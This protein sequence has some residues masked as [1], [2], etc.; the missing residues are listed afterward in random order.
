M[1]KNN[2]TFEISLSVLN[3][4]GRNLYRNFATVLGEA[5]SNAWD[6]DAQNVHIFIDREKDNFFISDDG[7]GMTSEDFQKKFLKIGYSKRKEGRSTAKNRLFI[8]RKGI[9]KLALLSCADKITVISKVCGV[10]YIG[11]TIDNSAL[12]QAITDDIAPQQYSLD[13]WEL[14]DFFQLTDNHNHGTIVRF[15][16]IKGGIRKKLD[17][18]KKITALYFRFSLLDDSFNIHINNEK[19]TFD[20]LDD[21]AQKTQFLWNIN[22]LEDPY[23][24]QK[25]T[26]LEEVGKSIQMN[27]KI[28]GFVA[29]VSK[30][31]DLKITTTDERVS[32]DLFVNGRLR[33]RDILKHIPTA[34]IA[35]NYFYGQIHFNE[36]DDDED[37]FTSGREGIIADDPKYEEFLQALRRE[38][39]KIVDDWD[40]LRV[41]LR[42]DGDPENKRIPKEERK[43][44]E[45]YNALSESFD[46]LKDSKSPQEVKGWLE[47]LLDDAKCN[48]TSYGKCFISEN[49]L[50]KQI[51]AN[52]WTPTSCT[53]VD[54]SGKTC[55]DRYNAK[56]DNTSLCEYCKGEKGKQN[57]QKQKDEAGISTRIRNT[58]DNLLMYLDYIDLVKIIKSNIPNDKDK[59]HKILKDE[60]RPYKL[61]RNSVMHTSR[62]TQEA[63]TKLISV[64]DNVVAT[65]KRIFEGS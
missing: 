35:E 65:V 10:D 19:I 60:D 59:L 4:L 42:K 32:I 51:E 40:K 61:L 26:N 62:L 22:N 57:L 46:L 25:L 23:I 47:D 54:Q 33:E 36:L 38:I 64:C 27:G 24:K 20:H 55:T 56:T 15:E 8:G 63:K 17:Y 9:G 44:A 29:S 1:S 48:F 49:L 31:A 43:A 53:N 50:R 11:G 45:L 39:L 7:I 34:R 2:F 3:H 52:R 13:T 41:A 6:A 28:Q 58:E 14:E 30:P 21:L 37:R 16:N 18:L 5:I 12:D